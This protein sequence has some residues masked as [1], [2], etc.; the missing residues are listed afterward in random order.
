MSKWLLF[1]SPREGNRGDFYSLHCGNL[2]GLLEI[3]LWRCPLDSSPGSSYLS[4]FSTISLQQFLNY[5]LSFPHPGLAGSI[6]GSCSCGFAALNSDSLYLPFCLQWFPCDVY[7]NSLLDLRRVF[8]FY[9][10]WLFCCCEDETVLPKLLT[11][12]SGN[13]CSGNQKYPLTHF[14]LRMN[15]CHSKLF[16]L[17]ITV[18]IIFFNMLIK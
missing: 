7:S 10:V 4:S 14:F 12:Y 9:F 17:P 3:T 2:V 6:S 16:S 13:H 5:R 18:S 11:C 8:N 1:P 15:F